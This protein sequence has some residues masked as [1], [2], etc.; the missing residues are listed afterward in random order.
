MLWIL[1][2]LT[3]YFF[4]FQEYLELFILC[5]HSS[6]KYRGLGTVL[7]EEALDRQIHQFGVF[8]LSVDFFQLGREC[9]RQIVF[10]RRAKREWGFRLVVTEATSY[11][12]QKIFL[13]LGFE[14][15]YISSLVFHIAV[16][17]TKVFSHFNPNSSWASPSSRTT[18]TQ[19]QA[20]SSSPS[21]GRTRRSNSWPRS[22][23]AF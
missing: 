6:R 1:T 3:T 16:K 12:T 22:Y 9:D 15:Q 21:T 2:K 23:E 4:L 8:P 19:P 11:Y 17:E 13:R 10:F 5:S 14:V 7:A 20:G 18:A